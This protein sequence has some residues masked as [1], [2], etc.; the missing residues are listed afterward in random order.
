MGT[1]PG[2]THIDWILAK[3]NKANAML[4]KI[5]HFL[6]QKTLKAIYHAIFESNLY[7]SSLVWAHNFISTTLSLKTVMTL[8]SMTRLLLKTPFLY[9]NPVNINALNFPQIFIPI[10]EGGR[11]CDVLIYLLTQLNHMEEILFVLAQFSL[12]SI[13]K[14]FL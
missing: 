9:I 12:G 5:R 14:I 13:F 2:N 4:S 8:N 6:D 10:R 3:L 7:F 1:W 11:I